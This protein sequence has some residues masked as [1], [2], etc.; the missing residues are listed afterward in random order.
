MTHQPDITHHLP[1]DMLMGFACGTLPEA[2]N[3]IVAAHVSICDSCRAETEGFDAIG[4]SLIETSAQP[5]AMAADSLDQTLAKIAGPAP[6]MTPRRSDPVLPQPLLDYIGG[7]LDDIRWR[8]IGMGV[9]QAVLKTS[10]AAT[11][12]LFYIPAGTAMPSHGHNGLEMTMVLQGAFQDEGDYF[13]RGDV[14]IANADVHH[15]P[16]ADIHQDCICLAVTDAPLRLQ[17][18]LPRLA[19]RFLG[20]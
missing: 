1:Q 8:P 4:G 9:K 20:I 14:E 19:Q 15:T 12:R 11:A 17:G 13:A 18:L 2:V 7:G 3:L 5:Q 10:A 16:V 6:A